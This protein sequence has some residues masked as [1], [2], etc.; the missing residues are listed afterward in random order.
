MNLI[1]P[2]MYQR[3]RCR[4]PAHFLQLA[5]ISWTRRKN[6][7]E[8]IWTICEGIDYPRLAWE[9]N[10]IV[11]THEDYL[12]WVSVD[13]PECWCHPTQCHGDVDGLV[14]RSA[15]TCYYH[16]GPFHFLLYLFTKVESKA[17]L[18]EFAERILHYLMIQ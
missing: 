7:S 11:C 15:K 1:I 5:G 18:L 13:K 16:V 14:G 2:T 9:P 3:P 17:T 10:C 8:D 12:E 6:D 4:Q